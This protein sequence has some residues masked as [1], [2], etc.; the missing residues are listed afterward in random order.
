MITLALIILGS[1]FFG[2]TIGTSIACCAKY[3]TRI[4]PRKVYFIDEYVS[5]NRI[6]PDDTIIMSNNTYDNIISNNKEIEE[7]NEYQKYEKSQT[8]NNDISKDQI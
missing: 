8:T 1:L 4:H 6:T 5:R 2:A 3:P 7:F